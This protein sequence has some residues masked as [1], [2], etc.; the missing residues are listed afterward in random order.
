M[1][2][3]DNKITFNTDDPIIKDII[4]KKMFN[5]ITFS[6][7]KDRVYGT[8]LYME[9]PGSFYEFV[10]VDNYLNNAAIYQNDFV[11]NISDDRTRT[12]VELIDIED[13]SEN[14][15]ANYDGETGYIYADNYSNSE[16]D[17]EK[18]RS[19]VSITIS[20]D[21]AEL[22]LDIIVK[23]TLEVEE[24]NDLNNTTIY[25]SINLDE[26]CNAYIDTNNDL[27]VDVMDDLR[28]LYIVIIFPDDKIPAYVRIY[29][30]KQV[31]ADDESFPFITDVEDANALYNNFNSSRYKIK[32]EERKITL[33][34][35]NM[36][37][38]RWDAKFNR[39]KGFIDDENIEVNEDGDVIKYSNSLGVESGSHTDVFDINNDPR[40]GRIN[41]TAYTSFC[42]D[43]EISL[44]SVYN[45][46]GE[47]LYYSEKYGYT[48]N[49]ENNSEGEYL[50]DYCTEYDALNIPEDI[51]NKFE[52]YVKPYLDDHFQDMNENDSF[53]DVYYFNEDAPDVWHMKRFKSDHTPDDVE[54]AYVHFG[55]HHIHITIDNDTHS[56]QYNYIIDTDKEVEIIKSSSNTLRISDINDT[57]CITERRVNYSDARGYSFYESA[58]F[59]CTAHDV[60]RQLS[61]HYS[62]PELTLD[63]GLKPTND[64]QLVK[65]VHVE[66]NIYTENDT[67]FYL[68]DMFGIPYKIDISEE[69]KEDND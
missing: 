25:T 33:D 39:I 58:T 40:N 42:G 29:N 62:S 2:N 43:D 5:N 46:L 54:L 10:T 57:D 35:D 64:G 51:K 7:N 21:E 6:S 27:D 68:R 50:E 65:E 45:G 11:I 41:S 4:K 18:G 61:N 1:S 49:R 28:A 14:I 36:S 66:S 22:K 30:D 63:Y 53:C 16:E 20:P 23:E 38:M 24:N 34:S 56:T 60:P 48:F 19:D 59:L 13:M 17:P 8:L 15:T 67:V 47:T 9:F 44:Y 32:K 69:S 55:K 3:N 12:D 52:T 26:K 31:S 37:I